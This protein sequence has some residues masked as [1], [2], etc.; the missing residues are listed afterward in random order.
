METNH[1]FDT[2][3]SSTSYLNFSAAPSS[4]ATTSGQPS[5]F[6]RSLHSVRKPPNPSKKSTAPLPPNPTRVYKVDRMNFRE[7]VQMLTGAA[8]VPASQQPRRLREVAPPPLDLTASVPQTSPAVHEKDIRTAECTPLSALY[9]ELMSETLSSDARQS[10]RQS[11]D[12]FLGTSG[13]VSL[14]LG[15]SPSPLGWCSV[16]LLSPETLA[17]YGSSKVL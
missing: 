2:S 16:P 7:L 10:Q 11:S 4:A 12:G 6:H 5:S 13:E 9:R 17:G 15:L 8:A 14:G 3:S 1:S